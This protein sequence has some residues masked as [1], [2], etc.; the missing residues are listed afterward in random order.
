MSG[1][2]EDSQLTHRG[3]R[4]GLRCS[5]LTSRAS[6]YREKLLYEPVSARPVVFQGLVSV[7]QR[8]EYMMKGRGKP[9]RLVMVRNLDELLMET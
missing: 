7:V 1:D 3:E 2:F 8:L 9:K 6:F 4:R 5:S